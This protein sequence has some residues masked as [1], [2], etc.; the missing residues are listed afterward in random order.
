MATIPWVIDEVKLGVI[1]ATVQLDSG[2]TSDGLNVA[3]YSDKTVHIS[4]GTVSVLGN[5]G[6]GTGQ[7]LHRVD[8]PSSTFTSV[9]SELLATIIENPMVI[10]ASAA[11]GTNVDVVIICRNQKD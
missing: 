10:V 7:A 6:I 4:G 3:D 2:D 8:S 9:A 5:N 1:R 11:A